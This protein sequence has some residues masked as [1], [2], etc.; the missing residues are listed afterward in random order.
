MNKSL[1]KRIFSN[2]R[3][4]SHRVL[5]TFFAITL[6]GLVACSTPVGTPKSKT[7]VVPI[8][9]AGFEQASA[10]NATQPD[11]WKKVPP[12]AQVSIDK[13]IKWQGDSSVLITRPAQLPFAGISQNIP[14]PAWRGK[15]LVL[16]AKLKSDA[17]SAGNN[18]LWLRADGDGRVGLQFANT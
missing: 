5:I 13:A 8:A 9:N 4:A 2:P 12:S 16:R 15:I 6:L 7:S 18:G 14:A 3:K 10:D 11:G 17:I 1:L